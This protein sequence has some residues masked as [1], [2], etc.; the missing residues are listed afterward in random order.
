MFPVLRSLAVLGYSSPAPVHN[1]PDF[2]FIDSTRQ[3][4]VSE[5]P[6]TS[7]GMDLELEE[8]TVSMLSAMSGASNSLFN[9]PDIEA[10][11]VQS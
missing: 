3:P 7:E 10:T 5:L 6:N 4:R 11:R 1:H 2:G 9:A 8:L